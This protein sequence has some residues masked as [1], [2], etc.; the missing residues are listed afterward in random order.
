MKTQRGKGRS[1]LGKRAR[2]AIAEGASGPK[3]NSA[4]LTKSLR[5]LLDADKHPGDEA[6]AVIANLRHLGAV[7][8]E[9]HP[10]IDEVLAKYPYKRR[11]RIH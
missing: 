2:I 6:I 11:E 3:V 1:T 10:L 8:A 4:A 7:P 9:A 5:A